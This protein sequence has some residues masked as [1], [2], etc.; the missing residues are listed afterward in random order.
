[1]TVSPTASWSCQAKP[2][3]WLST[4]PPKGEGEERKRGPIIRRRGWQRGRG[5]IREGAGGG[6]GGGGEGDEEGQGEKRRWRNDSENPVKEKQWTCG[7]RS[8]KG[9]ESSWESSE[10]GA[11]G[12]GKGEGGA[13]AGRGGEGGTESSWKRCQWLRKSHG[14]ARRRP[15]TGEGKASAGQRQWART[16]PAAP[17]TLPPPRALPRCTPS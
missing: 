2:E 11:K 14:K 6:G 9:S 1:M 13:L 4:V 12:Q 15:R 10:N 8:R 3:G 16:E 17:R 7:E 5:L